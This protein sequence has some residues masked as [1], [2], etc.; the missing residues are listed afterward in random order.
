M[1]ACTQEEATIFENFKDELT[2]KLNELRETNSLCDMM[3]RAQGQDFPAHRC[4]LM[5]CSQ[6]HWRKSRGVLW[7]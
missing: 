4:V 6:V 3:I 1:V 5:A 2:Y 7:S